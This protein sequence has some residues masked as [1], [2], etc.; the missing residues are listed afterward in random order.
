[1]NIQTTRIRDE[2]AQAWIVAAKDVKVYYLRP[3]MIMF[4]FF[5]PF[6]CF[7]RFR[8]AGKW[9]RRRVWLDC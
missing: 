1:M 4:G 9:Q 2:L 3:G 8:C 5:M 7:S 6:L